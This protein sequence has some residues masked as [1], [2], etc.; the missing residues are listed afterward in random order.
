M[1]EA[2][3]LPRTPIGHL[4]QSDSIHTFVDP[5][6]TFPTIDIRKH[7]PGRRR[8]DPRNQLFVTS[9]LGCLHARAESCITVYQHNEVE[10]REKQMLELTH[11]GI[12][13]YDASSH[14]SH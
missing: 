3:N 8:F 10:T 6:D 12:G 11:S 7:G 5:C 1:G 4:T 14:A 13:L 9:D 2:D